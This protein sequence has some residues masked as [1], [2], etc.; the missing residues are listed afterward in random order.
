M[1]AP[2]FNKYYI[3]IARYGNKEPHLKG[4][5]RYNVWQYTERGKI[6]GIKGYVDLDRFANGTTLR[7]ISL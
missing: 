6:K 5:G 4:G 1:L 3:F 2:E 7:D